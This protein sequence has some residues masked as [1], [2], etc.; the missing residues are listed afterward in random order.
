[1]GIAEGRILNYSFCSMFTSQTFPQ[2]GCLGLFGR[3]PRDE[4]VMALILKERTGH[5]GGPAGEGGP[6]DY[7]HSGV[8]LP[9]IQ[10]Q[11]CLSLMMQIQVIYLH[12]PGLS[13]FFS[14]HGM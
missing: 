1:M 7:A 2:C 3:G 10:S 5:G 8:R 6:L 11:L 12:S 4:L 14:K 13:L 9:G